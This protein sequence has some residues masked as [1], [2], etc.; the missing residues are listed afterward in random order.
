MS[1]AARGKPRSRRSADEEED[2]LRAVERSPGTSTGKF[3]RRHYISQITVVRVLHDQ[4]MYLLHA[5]TQT[6]TDCI[7]TCV[8]T[9][10]IQYLL[11]FHIFYPQFLIRAH[12]IIHSFPSNSSSAT[13]RKHFRLSSSR[14]RTNPLLKLIPA[15]LYSRYQGI[16]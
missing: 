9:N 2:A 13:V 10:F 12:H 4:M 11:H 6:H 15:T 7:C 3:T 16:N 1:H 8:H 5:H 14:N